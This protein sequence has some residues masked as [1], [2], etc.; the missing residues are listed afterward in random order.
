MQDIILGV[1]RNSQSIALDKGHFSMTDR[2]SIWLSFT[3]CYRRAK[4]AYAGLKVIQPCQIT[5]YQCPEHLI[6]LERDKAAR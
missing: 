4:S 6:G 1:A 5:A 2:Y 3:D